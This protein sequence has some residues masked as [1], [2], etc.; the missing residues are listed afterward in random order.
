M[1]INNIFFKKAAFMLLAALTAV[2]CTDDNDWTTDSSLSRLFGVKDNISVTSGD[3]YAE[4]TFNYVPEATHYIVELSTDPL[5]DDVPMG[6]ANAL[7]YG[8]DESIKPQS[9][10]TGVELTVHGL[11]GA[12]EY[13]L[14]V[15]ARSDHK[16]ESRWVYYKEGQTF[17]T[18][19]EQVFN[20]PTSTDI[21][22]EWVRLS[23]NT[24]NVTNILVQVPTDQVDDEGE[25]ILNT[26][27]NITLTDEIK[28][29]REYTVTG[30]TGS[31]SYIFTITNGDVKRGTLNI[32]TA[33]PMPAGNL[34]YE[35]PAMVTKI[36]NALLEELFE[37]AK[38]LAG[39]DNASVTIGLQGGST[40]ELST[41]SETNEVA[42][43]KIPEGMSVTF[44]GMPGETPTLV[45]PKSM[46]ID[47][48]HN[49]I[50]FENLKITER[51]GANY[52]I[53]QG[54]ACNINNITFKGC[55]LFG[56]GN[57]PF[58]LQGSDIKT[59]GNLTMDNCLIHDISHAGGYSLIHID[60][61]GGKGYVNN[62]LIQ[63]STIYNVKAANAR[64]IVQVKDTDME[65]CKFVN[66]TF[67]N[68]LGG[69]RY[70]FDSNGTSK[71]TSTPVVIENCLFG[72]MNTKDTRG[73]RNKTGFD[74]A[75]SYV[76][77]EQD[78]CFWHEQAE[79]INGT[80][81]PKTA[82]AIPGFDNLGKADTDI[83]ADPD[84]NDFTIKDE[85]VKNMKIGDPRWRN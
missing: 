53:N 67:R 47:G 75:N 12:T 81:F 16:T 29:A 24:D 65:S 23:W 22:D 79:T 5:S 21:S 54:K 52:L 42:G 17:K 28:A 48:S 57:T 6:G 13:Y 80:E 62:I 63:N 60:A 1:K 15:K 69:G 84:N 9:G 83:F 71:G 58:R 68:I 70:F 56:F 78:G 27:R 30:L 49:F 7:V 10:Y 44:F 34:K 50:N 18:L 35:L 46:N 72:H 64:C 74:V 36:D 37:Q 11:Q 38:E 39:S 43:V 76:T 25:T 59:I 14:R 61:G 55:E 26:I 20:I 2:S 73:G 51:S 31:T 77:Y 85:K 40:V 66:C 33:A 32:S 41:L 82:N 8:E 19:A 3:T 45:V 4:I